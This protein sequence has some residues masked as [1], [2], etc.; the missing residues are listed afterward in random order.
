[1]R[2]MNQVL[3]PLIGKF[4]VVYFD[5][6]L[7]YRKSNEVH[8]SHLREVLTVLEKS[9]LYVNL[10]KCSFMTKKLLFLGFIVSGDGI[11]VD[12]EK[13]KAIREWPIVKTVIEV[14]SF[15]GL[16][17]FYRHFIRHFSYCCAHY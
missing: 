9:K 14:R 12:E 8:L 1:M 4:F 16:V 7:I 13:I 15:H 6:I 5:N 3:K 17:T 2:L 11:Q 10:K